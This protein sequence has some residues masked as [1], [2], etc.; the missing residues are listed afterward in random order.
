MFRDGRLA[1]GERFGDFRD[2]GFAGGKPQEDGAARGIC[3]GGKGGV[4]LAG[5]IHSIT[6]RFYNHLVIY[7]PRLIVNSFFVPS[8]EMVWFAKTPAD[9]NLNLR[10]CPVRRADSLCGQNPTARQVSGACILASRP[11]RIQAP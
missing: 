1:H 4:Q 3:K 9:R 10:A 6:I 5:G 8:F 7:N 11:A 2:G